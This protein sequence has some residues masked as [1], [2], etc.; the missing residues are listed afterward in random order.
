MLR[1][2]ATHT[3]RLLGYSALGALLALVAVYIWWVD[4]LPDLKPWHTA[5]LDAEFTAAD[6]DE[7]RTLADYLAL[8][9]RL[10]RQLDDEVY[11]KVPVGEGMALN[12]Y[13]TASRADARVE[14]PDWNRTVQ[15]TVARPKGGVL[16]LH[17]LSDSPYSMRV[18]A[19]HFQAR[20]LESV[21]LRLPGHGTA[22]S[23]LLRTTWQDM[24]AA[25]RLAARDLS[26]RLPPGAP[27]YLVGYS[28]GAALA[29]EYALARLDGEP[30]PEVRGIVLLSPAIGVS[31]AAAFAV[32]QGRVST[33][34]GAPKVAW[35]DFLPEYDPYKYGS[36]TV[37]AAD[38]VYQLT[39]NIRQHLD[40]LG[41]QG[42]VTGMPPILAFS[43]VADATVSTPAVI[44]TLFRK[45]APG[46][47]ALVLFD[48]N[49]Y[50]DYDELMDP[51]R[52]KVKS[53]LLEGPAL[54]FDLTVLGNASPETLQVAF[55]QRPAGLA[56]DLPVATGMSWPP[57]V[58]SLSHVAL[59]F[60]D[61]DPVY[62]AHRVPDQR[63]IY[64]G[65]LQLAGEKGLLTV[66]PA[67]L[68]RLRHNPFFPYVLERVDAFMALPQ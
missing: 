62:G 23:G 42:P 68:M 53:D 34:L 26:S 57:E 3:L 21:A 47:H 39:E 24:A 48:I 50:A 32:W 17:G 22:P 9:E 46:D 55:F 11:A 16:L 30:L 6:A 60:A 58:Y 56:A 40:R 36:F 10:F 38:L 31:P 18:L 59:P 61:A 15:L 64:L 8:E 13:S 25:V 44:N 67:A 14:R 28:N 20:G 19:E 51:P 2:A 43:S 7:V 12:R 45:L 33:W 54:P 63:L 1:F 5:R 29:V 49:R 35:T 4:G 52:L 65:T 27:L 41:E 37:N 66:P